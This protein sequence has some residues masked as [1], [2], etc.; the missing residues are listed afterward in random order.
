MKNYH[1]VTVSGRIATGTTTLARSLRDR[2]GWTY[3]SGGEFFR[4]YMA[5]RGM[6]LEEKSLT[7]DEVEKEVDFG[8]RERMQN[9]KELVFEAWLS[10]FVAQGMGGVLKVLLVCKDD[11]RVDR[12]VNREA[13]SIKEAKDHIRRR[14]QENVKKWIRLYRKEWEDWVVKP[15]LLTSGDEIDFWHPKLYDLVIDTYSVSK[16]ETVDKVVEVLGV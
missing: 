13:S 8:M 7:E 15:G 5:K 10:G 2:L 16:E 4:D 11:L 9:E 14:E 3:W 1:C 12:F 6:P